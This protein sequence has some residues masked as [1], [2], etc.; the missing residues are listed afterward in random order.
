MKYKRITM[1]RPGGPDV[2]K[3]REE[4]LPEP[5]GNE[6]RIKVQAAGVGFADVLVR[7]GI[8]PGMPPF[9][10]TP[11]YDIVGSVDAI[12]GDVRSV[13]IGQTVAA[14]TVTGG[15]TEAII[16]PESEAVAVPDGL[17]AAEAVS[18]VLNYV[19]A[20]QMLH[21]VAKLKQGDPVLIHGAAGGVGTALLQLGR[22][23]GLR[24]YGT[25]SKQKHDIVTSHGGIAIDYRSENVERRIRDLEPDGIAAAFDATGEWLS[26]SYRLLRDD[27]SLVVYGASSMLERGRVALL[28]RL[29]TYLRFSIFFRNLLPGKK[30][31]SFYS[32]AT[33]KK[34]H[35]DRFTNDLS[36]LFELLKERKIEPLIAMRKPLD[37]AP[38]CHELL[39]NS[40][41]AGKMVLL[42]NG[43][44]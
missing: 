20:Y 29:R 4:E 36:R 9:P 19:T 39:N 43:D 3:L 1:E 44:L 33:H 16:L 30:R 31:I 18:L 2:L 37:E 25:A 11:G 35:P 40:A 41:I 12:G 22:L 10:V 34:K 32:I 38:L 8:Y 28:N 17:D 13:Q 23:A 7:T 27:G 21:H 15:Y 6:V 42:P 14:L 5:I 24:M 26:T